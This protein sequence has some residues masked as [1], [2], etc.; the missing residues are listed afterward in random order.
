MIV[1]R[2]FLLAIAM[3]ILLVMVW[4]HP[5]KFPSDIKWAI[6]NFFSAILSKVDSFFSATV[7]KNDDSF[8]N[9]LSKDDKGF[10][11][12]LKPR[13]FKFPADHGAHN[14][15]RTEW[16]YFTG[17]LKNSCDRKFGYELTFFRF[18]LAAETPVSKSACETSNCI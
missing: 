16:W 14:S 9:I 2:V 5:Y 3:I 13:E 12:A 15:Y 18:A 10:A 4:W 8:S 7:S 17:N 1:K 6:D 11:R